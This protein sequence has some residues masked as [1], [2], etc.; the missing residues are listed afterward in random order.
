MSDRHSG[1]RRQVKRVRRVGLYGSVWWLH[2]LECGHVERRKRASTKSAIGCAAC[3]SDERLLINVLRA[4]EFDP[5]RDA[6]VQIE[7]DQ[8]RAKLASALGVPLDAVGVQVAT[9]GQGLQVSGAMI[10]LHPEAANSVVQRFDSVMRSDYGASPNDT[11]QEVSYY[12]G[13]NE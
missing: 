9:G 7:A 4:P 12:F 11:E 2:D 3:K 13:E 1:P 5:G 8:L 10:F 6:Q